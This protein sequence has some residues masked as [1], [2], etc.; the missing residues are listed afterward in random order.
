VLQLR[1]G[2]EANRLEEP[3]A[4]A[5][6]PA[7]SADERLLHETSERVGDLGSGKLLRRA[8]GLGRFDLESTGEHG[9][10]SEQQPFFELEQLVTSPERRHERLLPRRRGLTAD[11]EQ[12]E[13]VVE[14]GGDRGRAERAEARGGELQCEREAVE[15]KADACDV[16]SVLR[17]EDEPRRRRRRTL[18]EQPHRFVARELARV[19]LP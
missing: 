9:E 6:L 8:D 14:T 7:I 15:A 16:R 12:A 1:P 4:M 3:I 17:V 10:P 5:T 11:A 2:V 18:R 19:E 13:A